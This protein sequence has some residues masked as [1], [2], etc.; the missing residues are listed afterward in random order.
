L[1]EIEGVDVIFKFYQLLSVGL[2]CPFFDF[3]DTYRAPTTICKWSH[4]LAPYS[5]HLAPDLK[6]ELGVGRQILPKL[7]LKWLLLF[8]P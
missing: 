3:D 6:K 5:K 8:N 1:F 7:W 2:V 4:F